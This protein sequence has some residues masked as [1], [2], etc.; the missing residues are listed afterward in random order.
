MHRER[1]NHNPTQQVGSLLGND[2]V[3]V[4]GRMLE[5][6]EVAKELGEQSARL[7]I[8]RVRGVRAKDEK[9]GQHGPHDVFGQQGQIAS[10]L[11]APQV[12]NARVGDQQQGFPPCRLPDCAVEFVDLRE[13]SVRGVVD[14]DRPDVVR[15]RAM[16]DESIIRP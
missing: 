11:E 10:A 4:V 14:H 12:A 2:A 7:P 6:L 13:P 15:M 3:V 8:P 1:N 5:F 16:G 9:E